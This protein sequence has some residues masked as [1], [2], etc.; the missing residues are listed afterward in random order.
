MNPIL[1]KR[2]ASTKKYLDGIAIPPLPDTVIKLK[3]ALK[4]PFVNNQDVVGILSSN[5]VLAGEFL[6]ATVSG[7]FVKK[8][9]YEISSITDAVNYI[10]SDNPVLIEVV[11]TIELKL[12]FLGDTDMLDDVVEVLEYCVDVASLCS[13]ISKEIQGLDKQEAYLFGLFVDCGY[14][15]LMTKHYEYMKIFRN[16]LTSPERSVNSEIDFGADHACAGYIVARDWEL[17]M[18][19]KAGILVHHEKID[20]LSINLGNKVKDMLH[21]YNIA[22]FMVNEVTFGRLMHNSFREKHIQSIGELGLNE[23]VLASIKNS[24]IVDNP[25]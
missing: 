1:L 12:S 20:D 22:S 10:G 4:S 13:E 17:P 15:I 14:L 3:E 7:R 18:W 5:S 21:V 2:Y 24:F 16:S 8:P 9:G 25:I 19:V 11:T 6:K 23:S